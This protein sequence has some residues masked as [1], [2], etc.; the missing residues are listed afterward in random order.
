MTL[1]LLTGFEPFGGEATNASSELVTSL[2]K[3]PAPGV[4]AVTAILPVTFTGA[5]QLLAELIAHHRPDVLLCLGEA[6][7][8]LE[9]TPEQ[10]AVNEATARIPDNAGAQPVG[11]RLDDGPDRLPSRLDPAAQVAAL[12]AAGL[13]AALSSDAGRFVCNA[14]FRAALTSFTGPAGFIHVPAVRRRGRAMIGAETDVAAAG[15]RSEL[16]TADL[17]HALRLLLT[18]MGRSSQPAM[19]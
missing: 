17:A 6:G 19:K 10:W 13:P 3:H 15:R 5:P 4:E 8:R 7:G 16:S 9:I 12:Q 2:S 1:V 11:Q 14:V 18:H